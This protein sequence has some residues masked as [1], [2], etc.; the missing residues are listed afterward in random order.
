MSATKKVKASW[1]WAS[2]SRVVPLLLKAGLI[3]KVGVLKISHPKAR[4]GPRGTSTIELALAKPLGV[5]KKFHLLDVAALSQVRATGV[6]TT[7]T[8]QVPAFNNLNDDS[9]PDVREAPS[10]GATMEKVASQPPSAYGEFLR[11]SF[12]ILFVGLD[13]F[14]LQ[15]LS[16]LCLC[17]IFR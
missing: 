13:D 1:G 5:S 14:F 6:V 7:H 8:A 9:S 11:F 3:K 15:T 12:V 4:L 16:N 10:P 2:L 17:Q